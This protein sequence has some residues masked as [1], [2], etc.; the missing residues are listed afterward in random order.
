MTLDYVTDVVGHVDQAW[1]HGEGWFVSKECPYAPGPGPFK[2]SSTNC[3]NKAAKQSNFGWKETSTQF[4]GF[5]LE[6]GSQFDG[7]YW[8]GH[9]AITWKCYKAANPTGEPFPDL[10]PEHSV[11]VPMRIMDPDIMAQ[12]SLNPA[13][14][15]AVG[16]E[17]AEIAETIPQGYEA[18]YSVPA[19]AYPLTSASGAQP[20]AAYGYENVRLA[21]TSTETALSTSTSDG[22]NYRPS[23]PRKRE[24]EFKKKSRAV[25]KP[26]LKFIGVATEGMDAIRAIY[27]ALHPKYQYAHSWNGMLAAVMH[28]TADGN[29]PMDRIA[30]NIFWQQMDDMWV[31]LQ[32]KPY[33]DAVR[34]LVKM[35]LWHLPVGPLMM[36]YLI[37]G[38]RSDTLFQHVVAAANADIDVMEAF[39][40]ILYNGIL[41]KDT[42]RQAERKRRKKYVAKHKKLVRQRYWANKDN[43]ARIEAYRLS[44]LNRR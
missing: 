5:Y 16:P 10:V 12:T 39:R 34:K 3:L 44:R 33:N 24:E 14:N 35:K 41:Q 22:N 2:Y 9:H 6:D 36:K 40:K 19:H 29:L 8:L 38:E 32:S 23:R 4:Y 43:I 1:T 11:V 27:H 25:V 26:F 42:P 21:V 13:I 37:T 18:G 15:P 17:I 28:A 30:E 20:P 7:T 31:G